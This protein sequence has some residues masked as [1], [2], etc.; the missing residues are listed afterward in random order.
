MAELLPAAVHE[1]FRRRRQEAGG[2]QF[3]GFREPA[4]A[5]RREEAPLRGGFD[6]LVRPLGKGQVVLAAGAI[7]APERADWADMRHRAYKAICELVGAKYTP[8]QGVPASA[9]GFGTMALA[10]LAEGVT[11]LPAFDDWNVPGSN[12]SGKGSFSPATEARPSRRPLPEKPST[13]RWPSTVN[14]PA[15]GSVEVPFLFAW[16]YP[17]K[18]KPDFRAPNEARVALDGLPLRDALGRRPGGGP[19]SGRRLAESPAAD[20]SLPQDL[21]RQHAALL[22]ARLHHVAGGHDSPHRRRLPLANGDVY[23][24][25]GSN[26]CC[27]PTCTHVWG[28][29]QSLSRLFPDLEKMMRRIDFKHQQRP[30]GGV[31]N[32]TAVPSPPHPTRR[33]PFRRRPRQLHPQGVPRGAEPSGR[34]ILQGVL[35]AR[36]A[37]GRILDRPRRGDHRRQAARRPPRR[38]VQHLRRGPARRDLVHFRLLPGRAARGEEWAKRMGDQ[39]T[40]ARFHEI[41]LAGQENLVR[42]CWNGEYFQQDLPDYKN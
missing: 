23:G 2:A 15:G 14:V 27:D 37:G 41:F 5:S 3:A 9:C 21:L 10:A 38:P 20:G 26:G 19:R 36:E 29:E 42:R 7:L 35:A 12:S 25:E 40:A 11:V 33:T 34:R 17:N 13:A 8:P 32:R 18:Y 24:W 28:Y 22:D 6:V 30:D 39:P 16:R 1:N 31:N 4:I